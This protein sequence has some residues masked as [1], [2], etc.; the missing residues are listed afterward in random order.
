MVFKATFKNISVISWLTVLLDEE[1]RIPGEN[2]QPVASHGQ[3]F[4]HNVVSSA[5]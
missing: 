5:H 4:S 3:T 1:T 2:N